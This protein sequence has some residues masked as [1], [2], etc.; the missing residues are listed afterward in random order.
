MFELS[1]F[2]KEAIQSIDSGFHTLVTAHTGSGKTLPAEHAIRHFTNLGK[3]VIYT[4]PIKAL[5]N[6]KY[7]EFSSKFPELEIG[8]LTGDNKHNPGA[9]VIIMTTEILQNNLFR[10][11]NAYLTIEMDIE[12]ELGCVIFDEVHYIDDADRGTVWEQC[13]IMLPKHVQMVMLSAT[14]GEKER[15]AKWIE[16]IKENKV[17]ICSTNTRV[18]PLIHYLYFCVPPKMLE[19][20]DPPTK[21][22]FE[23]KNNVLVSL[24]NMEDVINKN[25]KCLHYLKSNDKSVNRKYVVNQLCDK[26]REKEMF[27]AL[28]FVFSRKQV[29]ELANDIMVPLFNEGEKDYEIEPICRQLLVSKVSN[30]K[31]Y[32]MLPEYHHYLKLLHK[33]IGVHHA[34]MLPIFR[35]MIEIL[36]DKK[37]IHVLFAT[38]TFSIGLNMPTKTV[39]FTSL[40]KHDGNK[41]RLLYSH[42]FTQMCG[43]AGRRNIDNV[44]HVILL[45]N[46]YNQVDT[47]YYHKLLNSGPKV[48]KSKFK[49]SY[50]L[51]LN[52]D[53]PKQNIEH[54]LMYQDILNE[55]M[56]AD[57]SISDLKKIYDEYAPLLKIESVCRHYLNLKEDLSIAKNKIRKQIL[58]EIQTI[59]SEQPE[60]ETQLSLYYKISDIKVDIQKHETYREYAQGYVDNQISA[61]NNVLNE[62]HFVDKKR[63]MAMAIHEIHP[64]VFS[65]MYEK[66]D[67]F[68][69]HSY[70][71][72]F[73]LLSCMYDIKVPDERKEHMPAEL[74]SELKYMS[75]RMEY[76]NDQEVKY[77]LCSSYTTIQYD[78]MK[79]IKQWLNG[80]TNETEAVQLIHEMKREKEWFTGDFIKCCLKLVNMA[81]ELEDVCD[82]DFL[83][84]IKEG[85]KL[86]KFV[87]TNE[88]LY[89]C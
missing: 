5:S 16:T 7:A 66:Y 15:F 10:K 55:I 32:M 28:F 77:E 79:Y 56:H 47:S 89:L 43:R 39:C 27:P 40:Y 46:L 72:I 36:Y 41:N 85:S 35:E 61:I 8:I 13:I 6:Q 45:T 48:L 88:S 22:L 4:S 68:K 18:V 59:E 37:Y 21:K 17:V 82:L 57:T 52:S 19:V 30:W 74:K 29:E 9:D 1:P 67:G 78:M 80:C 3:K 75:E 14:I 83:E 49:I 54:S 51:L 70:T 73:C 2:Q 63:D 76:Y 71:D 38:E 11:K 44:G 69:K 53:N 84:K 23:S 20:M 25:N 65:D 87:C 60:F 42:E 81:K 12:N 33:G 26:M 86:L 58:K 62:N 34:G 31:E 50:S 64:L 24:E